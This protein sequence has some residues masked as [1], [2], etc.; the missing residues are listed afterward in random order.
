MLGRMKRQSKA[1]A[2]HIVQAKTAF[3]RKALPKA[4]L[5]IALQTK[6]ATTILFLLR[7]PR[8]AINRWDANA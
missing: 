3:Q 2:M 7:T 1:L 5:T 4:G 8:H 6:Q